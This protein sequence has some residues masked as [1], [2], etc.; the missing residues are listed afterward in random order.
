MKVDLIRFG[1]LWDEQVQVHTAGSVYS[2]N[3]LCPTLDT[4]G[5]YTRSIFC[6]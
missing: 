3:G 5:G 6:D 4:G 1:G 2:M